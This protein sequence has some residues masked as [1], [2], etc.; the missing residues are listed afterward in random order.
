MAD[1]TGKGLELSALLIEATKI[2]RLWFA[3]EH[4]RL[5]M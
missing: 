4:S 5:Q 3:I 2:N 1:R